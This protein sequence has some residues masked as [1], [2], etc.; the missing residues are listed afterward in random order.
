MIPP[1]AGV[2]PSG[3]SERATVDA[4]GQFPGNSNPAVMHRQSVPRR[5]SS[6]KALPWSTGTDTRPKPDPGVSGRVRP[7]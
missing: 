1:T 6:V 7:R 2:D 5:E 4:R 3:P